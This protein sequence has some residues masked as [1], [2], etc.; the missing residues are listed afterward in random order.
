MFVAPVKRA[1]SGGSTTRSFVDH[2]DV[3]GTPVFA[4]SAASSDAST[5]EPGAISR[6]AVGHTLDDRFSET[7]SEASAVP[8]SGEPM[9]TI[10]RTSFGCAA[11]NRPITIPPAE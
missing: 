10:W 7:A 3:H 1:E 2:M 8:C 9:V 5:D 6:H 4:G 11:T